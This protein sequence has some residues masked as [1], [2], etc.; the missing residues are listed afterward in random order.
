MTEP[1]K[2]TEVK[3]RQTTGN[4]AVAEGGM[5]EL[6]PL[7]VPKGSK[8]IGEVKPGF[9]PG[10]GSPYPGEPDRLFNPNNPLSPV[11]RP[12]NPSNPAN[13][14][15]T[16]SDRS[17]DERRAYEAELAKDKPEDPEAKKA[18]EETKKQKEELG[19]KIAEVLKKFGDRESSIPATHEYWGLV[20]QLRA[21]N[22]P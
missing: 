19:K 2:P 1:T 13:P 15:N 5:P 3:T 9:K 7:E 6:D 14:P 16:Q 12:G 8:A 21:L 17:A 20:A 11:T 18:A 22:N 4:T 10:D